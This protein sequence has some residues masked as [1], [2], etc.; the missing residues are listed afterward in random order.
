[1]PPRFESSA[2]PAGQHGRKIL[3]Q[4]AVAIAKPTAVDDHGMIEQGSVAVARGFQLVEKIGELLDVEAY[5]DSQKM[6]K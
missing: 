6:L 5:N 1:M 3:V 2:A 4:V